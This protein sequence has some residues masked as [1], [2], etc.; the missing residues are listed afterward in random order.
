MKVNGQEI[1]AMYFAFDG[2][3]KIYLLESEKDMV[4]AVGLD[5]KVLPIEELEDTYNKS[6][7]LRFIYLWDL[8]ETIVPQCAENVV[9]EY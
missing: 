9:F 6:C 5:Y 8:T 4:E 7:P 3:H 2:C 1:K